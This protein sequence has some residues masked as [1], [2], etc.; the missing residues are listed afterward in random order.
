MLLSVK[1]A[2]VTDAAQGIGHAVAEGFAAEG[3]TVILV[4]IQTSVHEAANT[5]H[6]K[7]P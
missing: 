4:D 6:R 7:F 5:L 1:L 3:A 2:I